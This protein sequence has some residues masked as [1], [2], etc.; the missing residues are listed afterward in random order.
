RFPSTAYLERLD[1]NFSKKNRSVIKHSDLAHS[2]MCPEEASNH[3]FHGSELLFIGS[4]GHVRCRSHAAQE[5]LEVYK[6]FI[7]H[8][9]LGVCAIF[10]EFRQVST[11][12]R[13]NVCAVSR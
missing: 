2:L 4:A 13:W 1:W 8:G 12:D 11:A 3:F 5:T 10:E 9:E 7:G 6:L